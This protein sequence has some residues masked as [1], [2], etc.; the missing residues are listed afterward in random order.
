MNKQTGEVVAIKKLLEEYHTAEECM[1]L[2][3]VKSL[4][5]MANHP[6]IVKLKE[7]I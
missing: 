2:I 7:V 5:K 6:N 1:N 4:I 3:E